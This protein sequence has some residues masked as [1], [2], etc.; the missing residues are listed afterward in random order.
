MN[1]DIM[2]NEIQNVC[3]GS[4]VVW[5]VKNLFDLY[6]RKTLLVKCDFF[7]KWYRNVYIY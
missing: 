2:N 1:C 5:S 4:W 3:L 7:Q 6:V